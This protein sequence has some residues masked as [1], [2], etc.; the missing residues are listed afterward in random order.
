MTGQKHQRAGH[1][2]IHDIHRPT[3]CGMQPEQQQLTKLLL[4]KKTNNSDHKRNLHSSSASAQPN[5]CVSVGRS[6]Y[7]THTVHRNSRPL[8]YRHHLP[9]VTTG[10]T[11]G[12]GRTKASIYTTP[13]LSSRKELHRS[14]F[15]L[16]HSRDSVESTARVNALQCVCTV[17]VCIPCC[18][19]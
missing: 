16:L 11:T 10:V 13:P 7:S 12:L 15:T 8:A 3:H 5:E 19:R 9:R 1:N 6:G 2:Q 4:K 14:N 18:A 17:Y